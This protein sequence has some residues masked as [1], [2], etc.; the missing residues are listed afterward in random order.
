MICMFKFERYDVVKIPFKG[1]IVDGRVEDCRVY[2]DSNEKK[3]Y[4]QYFVRIRGAKKLKKIFEDD[5]MKNN[6]NGGIKKPFEIVIEKNEIGPG[7]SDLRISGDI[8]FEDFVYIIKSKYLCFD[9]KVK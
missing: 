6:P 7:F 4:N 1:K 9:I 5:L 8:D 3:A 2:Y